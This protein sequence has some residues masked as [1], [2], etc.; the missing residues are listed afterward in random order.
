MEF[1]VQSNLVKNTSYQ[2]QYFFLNILVSFSAF[3]AT[4]GEGM[5]HLSINVS[6]FF[7]FAALALII[8]Y[9]LLVKERKSYLPKS[10]KYLICFISFHTLI[11]IFVF[12][13]D[14]LN[15]GIQSSVRLQNDF[16]REIEAGGNTIL[17]F[18]I[19]C[20]YSCVLTYFLLKDK[21]LFFIYIFFYSLGF[22]VTLLIGGRTFI[23]ENTI[24]VSGGVMD[25]NAMAFSAII[26]FFG[27]LYCYYKCKKILFRVL[28]I[29]VML[30][31]FVGVIVSM[32]RGGILAF[33]L[34]GFYYLIHKYK[35]FHLLGIFLL[36]VVML[37]WFYT[38]L[39]VEMKTAIELRF[40]IDKAKEDR[41]AGRLDVWGD[42]LSNIDKYFVSGM[43]MANER[44]A[45]KDNYTHRLNITHNQYL[46]YFVEYGIIGVLLFFYYIVSLINGI[47]KGNNLILSSIF[48]AMLV[49][50]FTLDIDKTRDY[51][52]VLAWM[53]T[54]YFFYLKNR[55]NFNEN[56]IVH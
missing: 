26:S 44:A 54:E 34:A 14:V 18:F 47:M 49:V 22:V 53:N 33:V 30:I 56:T 10:F 12:N 1:G 24:R 27:G 40:S 25:P 7:L 43:G 17:R 37:G 9:V 5:Q 36:C 2:L 6:K 8:Y 28:T 16:S 29:G 51:W 19:F 48:I 3:F 38:R 39:P 32:S 31:S 42:Y 21:K 35:F 4:W 45:I 55:I 41:G 20:A 15:F 13:P 23:A 46:Q 50:M 11:Y 52:I